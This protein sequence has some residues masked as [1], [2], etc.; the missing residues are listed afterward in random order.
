MWASCSIDWP[1]ISIT[2]K[3]N[4]LIDIDLLYIVVFDVDFYQV[5]TYPGLNSGW[6]SEW[7]R[8]FPEFY[9][10]I[11]GV[12]C[13]VGLKFLKIWTTGKFHSIRPF[14]LGPVSWT[15]FLWSN[16]PENTVPFV[17]WNNQNFKLEYLVKWKT[18]QAEG[19]NFHI[20]RLT[21]CW[22][23]TNC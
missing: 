1:I 6:G 9:S 4:L 19:E 11:L 22:L 5:T 8:Y 20:K 18:P 12:P 10:E 3:F 14:L 17:T 13:K 23:L 15:Q 16:P 2:L 7:D 21:L